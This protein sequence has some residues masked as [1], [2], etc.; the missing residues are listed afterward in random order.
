MRRPK[1]FWAVIAKDKRNGEL[2]PTWQLWEDNQRAAAEAH[3][4]Q[5][6]VGGLNEAVL[7]RI[8]VPRKGWRDWNV[9]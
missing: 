3:A 7:V 5:R 2:S 8:P 1:H 4:R 6:C 9:E